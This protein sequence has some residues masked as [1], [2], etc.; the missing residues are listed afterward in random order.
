MQGLSKKYSHLTKDFDYWENLVW[1]DIVGRQPKKI[2]V[3]KS[4]WNVPVDESRIES[5]LSMDKHLAIDLKL[6]LKERFYKLFPRQDNTVDVPKDVS[7]IKF[8]DEDKGLT[9]LVSEELENIFQRFNFP[10]FKSRNVLESGINF[11]KFSEHFQNSVKISSSPV[12]ETRD[13]LL[14]LYRTAAHVN[15]NLHVNNLFLVRSELSKFLKE[16]EHL[17]DARSVLL[18]I[19]LFGK[20][21]NLILLELNMQKLYNIN[22]M[23]NLSDTENHVNELV[24]NIYEIL[25]F[26]ITLH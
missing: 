22:K 21:L 4:N 12:K 24:L 19:L 6:V 23:D 17:L 15:K 5:V 7:V 2:A 1:D 14:L 13:S 20:N 26:D 25:K 18:F 8:L 9:A 10:S 3:L 11:S 16:K